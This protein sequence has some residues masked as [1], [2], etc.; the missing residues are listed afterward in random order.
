MLDLLRNSV[1]AIYLVQSV[2]QCFNVLILTPDNLLDVPLNEL[3]ENPTNYV[4]EGKDII[5]VCRLGNDSKIGAD[6]I[7]K[8]RPDIVVKDMVGGLVAW[9]QRI[10]SQFPIY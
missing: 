1:Y 3:H 7:R 4:R 6:L 5:V 2:S 9:A 8:S 10:D